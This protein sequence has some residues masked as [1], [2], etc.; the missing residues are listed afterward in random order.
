VI[1]VVLKNYEPAKKM[2]CNPETIVTKGGF[3]K[4]ASTG[5][6]PEKWE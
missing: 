4:L 1:L 3:K 2:G 6:S 5:I